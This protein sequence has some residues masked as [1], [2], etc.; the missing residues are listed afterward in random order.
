MSCLS[1]DVLSHQSCIKS[2]HMLS[3]MEGMGGVLIVLLFIGLLFSLVAQ[4]RAL[5]LMVYRRAL[6]SGR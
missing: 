3:F 5:R 6:Y 2:D 1:T 4:H